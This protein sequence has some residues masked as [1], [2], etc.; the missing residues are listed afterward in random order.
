ME[1]DS[2][3][4]AYL[5]SPRERWWGILRALSPAGLTLRGLSLESFES[6]ARSVARQEE[7]ESAPS[8]VFFP[9]NRVERMYEDEGTLQIPSHAERFRELTGQDVRLV[10]FRG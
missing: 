3:V 9:M 6:W 4:V 2:F 8:T 10:L 1:I 5:H 7:L